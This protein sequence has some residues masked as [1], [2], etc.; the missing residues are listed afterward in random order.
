MKKRKIVKLI[1]LVFVI[2]LVAIQLIPVDRSVPDADPNNDFLV[3]IET[4]ESIKQLMTNACYDCH[5]YQTKYPWYAYIAPVSMWLQGHVK[6]G[7]KHLNFS[8]WATYDAESRDHK[9]EEMIENVHDG[10]MPL[11]SYLKAHP[12]ARLTDAQRQELTDWFK[13]VR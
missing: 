11:N 5:S 7:R 9:L 10:L 12:E 13:L 8:E 6:D 1:L 4:S 2:V 3:A